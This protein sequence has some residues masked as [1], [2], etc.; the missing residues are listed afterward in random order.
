MDNLTDHDK[1]E[2]EKK[3]DDGGDLEKFLFL[4]DVFFPIAEDFVWK[5]NEAFLISSE[6]YTDTD[7]ETLFSALAKK[8]TDGH[9]TIFRF[10]SGY[11]AGFGTPDIRFG[12]DDDSIH[13][14]KTSKTIRD[15]MLC[16]IV[17][18]KNFQDTTNPV[19]AAGAK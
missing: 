2:I 14:C 17:D 16:A 13:N 1:I 7:I 10:T 3:A 12:G 8:Y 19:I 18:N 5:T 4:N 9:Y 6:T 15:A 11:K